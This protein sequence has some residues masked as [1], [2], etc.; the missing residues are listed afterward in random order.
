MQEYA[1]RLGA[2]SQTC[3]GD[4]G[5]M[6]AKL[7]SQREGA[8]N[9]HHSQLLRVATV[10]HA[11]AVGLLEAHSVCLED[12]RRGRI[13]HD[14]LLKFKHFTIMSHHRVCEADSF[15]LVEDGSGAR[16]WAATI[17]STR[18]RYQS[19]ALI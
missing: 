15:S 14:I 17:R 19:S 1:E 7:H 16:G 3:V 11:Y 8:Q 13:V 10:V 12:R 9:L 2:W 5:I 4:S 18:A 6:L